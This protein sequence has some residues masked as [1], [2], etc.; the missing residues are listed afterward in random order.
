[1]DYLVDCAPIIGAILLID[2]LA[3]IS[4]GPNF[5]LVTSAALS[6]SRRIAVW[7]ACGIAA[8]SLV[9]ATAAALGIASVFA[10]LPVLGLIIKVAGIAYLL[11]LGVKLLRSQGYKPPDGQHGPTVRGLSGFSRGLLVNMTNPKSA[12]YYASVF[13]VFLTPDMPMTVVVAL[14]VAIFLMSLGWHVLLAV[15]LS[16]PRVQ[17]RFVS[18]SKHIDRLCGA[19]LLFLGLRLAWESR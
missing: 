13:A 12:A 6:Q 3:L 7:T 17:A 18:M 15:G 16:V 4:P 2:L 19:V 11:Y 14:V 9:W 1:M 8:G 5:V 10:A